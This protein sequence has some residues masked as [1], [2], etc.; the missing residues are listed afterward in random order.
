M[1]TSCPTS[2][3]GQQ[4]ILSHIPVQPEQSSRGGKADKGLFVSRR[5]EQDN[6]QLQVEAEASRFHGSPEAAATK[7]QP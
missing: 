5:A 1:A 3:L 6:K 4:V 7:P 2:A